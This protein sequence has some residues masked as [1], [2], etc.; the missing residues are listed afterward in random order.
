MADSKPRRRQGGGSKATAAV[1]GNAAPT[2]DRERKKDRLQAPAPSQ[3]SLASRL[4]SVVALAAIAA[5]LLGVSHVLTDTYTF[6]Y[7]VPV[8]SALLG[9]A[10]PTRTA[11]PS[12]L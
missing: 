12:P 3:T 2:H 8:L 11:A 10:A 6:G 7:D 4:L 5:L 1:A 9:N